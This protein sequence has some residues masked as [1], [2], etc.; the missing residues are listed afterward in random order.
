MADVRRVWSR[1]C[2]SYRALRTVG[3][4][5]QNVFKIREANIE[6]EDVHIW[7][8]DGTIAFTKS[9]DGHITG[10]LFRGRR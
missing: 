8:N 10:A 7:L 3:L 1:C 4:D 9:V 6:R 5:P 2:R